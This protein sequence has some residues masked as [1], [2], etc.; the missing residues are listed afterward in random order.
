M[1]YVTIPLVGDKSHV[2]R[3]SQELPECRPYTACAHVDVYAKPWVKRYCRCPGTPCSESLDANDNHTLVSGT[4]LIKMC[5]P[6]KILPT[7]R[8]FHDYTW[9][10]ETDQDKQRIIQTMHCVC[11]AN[12]QPYL[13]KTVSPYKIHF[14]CSPEMLQRCQR[15]EPCRLFTV[16]RDVVEAATYVTL[17]ACPHG[18]VCPRHHTDPGAVFSPSPLPLRTM[19]TYAGYCTAPS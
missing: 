18:H 2:D 15:K 7:C 19:R 1:T 5:E 8:P 13:A 4:R 17:C 14:A 10:F 11:P 9:T 12:T 6:V 3:C 16:N